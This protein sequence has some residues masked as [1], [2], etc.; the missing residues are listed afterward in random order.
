M[1]SW[2]PEMLVIAY[3]ELAMVGG[4]AVRV[5]PR[6]A[7]RQQARRDANPE[8][9][10][11][12]LIPGL[13]LRWGLLAW[14]GMCALALLGCDV[15]RRWLVHS[16]PCVRF[17][18]L[19]A[20]NH[21]GNMDDMW[22]KGRGPSGTRNASV[23]YPERRPRGDRHGSHTMPERRARG[24]RHGRAKLTET[25]V[26]EIRRLAQQGVSQ[27]VIGERFGVHASTVG[28]IARGEHWTHLKEKSF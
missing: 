17:E 6:I 16:E 13:L 26:V 25:D 18:H 27:R 7:R 19:F 10:W 4:I 8:G 21:Q 11:W 14:W 9:N 23:L 24:E 22:A 20:S 28:F 3:L 1:P 2:L 5:M 12:P 15:Y